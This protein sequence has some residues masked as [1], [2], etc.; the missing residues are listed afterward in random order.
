M[1]FVNG[2]S[3]F[4]FF[5]IVGYH[6]ITVRGASFYRFVWLVGWLVGQVCS[7]RPACSSHVKTS[8][9]SIH[10]RPQNKQ[11]NTQSTHR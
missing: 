8:L 4:V 11:T 10:S 3:V 9:Q 2:L 7:F 5:A 6:Y 1:T